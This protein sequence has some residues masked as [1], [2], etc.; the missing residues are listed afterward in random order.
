MF[1]L[2]SGLISATIKN[3][4]YPTDLSYYHLDNNEISF[5]I[6]FDEYNS[7]IGSYL[8]TKIS[9]LIKPANDT[10]DLKVQ[11]CHFNDETKFIKCPLD[12]NENNR[13][14]VVQTQ[15]VRRAPITQDQKKD[16]ID[17]SPVL[18]MDQ[19]D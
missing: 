15:M 7:I 1:F 2:L 8:D 17:Q 3:R 4:A 5:K 19:L 14:W 13:I 10:T 6:K 18:S 16:V 11:I 12:T 9:F